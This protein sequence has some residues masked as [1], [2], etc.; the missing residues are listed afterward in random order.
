MESK[1]SSYSANTIQVLKGLEAVRKRPGMYIGTTGSEGLHHLVYEVVDNSIDEALAGFCKKIVV[2]LERQDIIR[3]EDDGRGI[4]VDIHPTEGISALELVMTRLHAGGKFDKKNYKVS[5][6][7]HGVGV[8]VV[9]ALSAWL[10]VYVHNDGKVFYQRYVRGIAEKPVAFIGDTDRTGTIVR[11]QADPDIFEETVYSFD[12]LS[13]RLR[14]LAFL[15]K[16]IKIS[17]I[18]ERLSQPKRIEFHFEGGLQEFVEYL[19]KNKTVIHKDVIYFLGTR[20]EVEIE[21]GMQYNDGYNETMFTYVNGI[22]T[23]EGG[24]HLIGFRNALTKVVNDFFKKSKYS[25]KIEETLSGDD[26]REG[27]TAVLSIKVLEPQFEGQTKSKLGNTE[28][29]GIVEGFFSEQLDL[30]FQKNPEVIDIILGKC[31]TAARARIAARQARE[32]TRRKSL[33]EAS[34]LPGKLADCQEKDPSK[35]ELFIVEG[36]SAGGSAKMGRDRLFQAILP[37]WG[38][39]LNVEKARLDK[40]IGNDKLQPIIASLGTGIG[41]D[42]DISKLRY[43]K[44]II[45]ADAD[46]D[47]SHIRTLLLTFFYRYMTELIERGHVYLAMPPLYRINYDKEIHYAYSD[48]DKDKLLLQS[49][50]DPSKISVQRYKGLGEM[51]PEQLWETTMDP[52]RRIIKRITMEDAI[53]AEEMFVTLMGEQVE[54]RRRFIEENALEVSNLDV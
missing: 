42:F 44:V 23:K 35:C 12:V 3:V 32:L 4:P 43:H 16:G 38:K 54:P 31:A 22:N 45:M 36:D 9:N 14:E 27:L 46:V 37:L 28:V 20:D 24:T 11:F 47:G 17:L 53:L 10:E 13:N 2:A 25:K 7:L 34:S 19:N 41:E 1:T 49:N 39:M 33:L 18:D 29:K 21:I 48:E 30:Y 5:G 52:S 6:G 26:V 15:N 8:S 40:V 50:K 51:N